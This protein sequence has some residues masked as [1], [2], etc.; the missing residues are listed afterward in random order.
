LKGR[1]KVSNA[2]KEEK[3]EGRTENASSIEDVDGS[4]LLATLELV[5]LELDE[6]VAVDASVLGTP[7][8]VG[9]GCGG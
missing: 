3:G 2:G 1:G 6:R 8:R 4:L 9:H 5:V 7:A